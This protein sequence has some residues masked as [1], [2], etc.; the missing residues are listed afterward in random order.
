MT[1]MRFIIFLLSAI[2]FS[3]L[4]A[5]GAF[6]QPSS[7]LAAKAMEADTISAQAVRNGHVRVI[8]LFEPPV[9]PSQAQHDA[10]GI[11]DRKERVAAVRDAIIATHFVS[12]ASP[13]AGTGFERGITA[14]EITPGF[15]VNVSAAE[16]EALAA[17]P[18]VS[19][20]T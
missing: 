8:V 18:R 7:T 12:A 9:P 20:I 14:F 5:F 17:D 16:L 3:A 19:S 11:A 4:I 2:F 1:A 6:A 15:A 13:A 10:A